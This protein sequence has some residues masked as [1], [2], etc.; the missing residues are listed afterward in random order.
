[1]TKTFPTGKSYS[2]FRAKVLAVLEG[3]AGV[4]FLA[5]ISYFFLTL[6]SIQT[7]VEVIENA[8]PSFVTTKDFDE[9]RIEMLH[10]LHEIEKSNLQMKNELLNAIHKTK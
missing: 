8:S 6:S 4:A 1:M 9:A 5:M 7:K 3:A 2:L 10:K